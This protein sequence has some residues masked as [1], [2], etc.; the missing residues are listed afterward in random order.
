MPVIIVL[1]AFLLTTCAASAS[2]TLQPR[3]NIQKAIDAAPEG[4]VFILEP[5]VYRLQSFIPKDE[6]QFI[7]RTGAILNGAV[8]L[9][10]WRKE[11]GFW[12]RRG[13]PEPL[14]PHGRCLSK[15]KTCKHREDLFLNNSLYLRVA[16]L[17]DLG[18]GK[19]L[20]RSGV[21]YLKDDPSGRQV[22]LS[23][24]PLA[25]G[26]EAKGIVLKNLVVEKYASAA[27][28]GAIDARDGQDWQVINVIARWNHGIG[29]FI[30]EGMHV[31]GGS[32]N[33]NGQMGMG[34]EGSGAIIENVEIAFN[35]YAA[36]SWN[37]EAGGTK[38][39]RSKK[40]TVRNACV[41][42][43]IGPGLWTDIDN[44]DVLYEGNIVFE[45]KGDGIK[46]EISYKAVIRNNIAAR[47]GSGKDN[48]LWG[49]Q[50]LIQN[51]PNVQVYGN[52]VEVAAEFGNG[53]SIICKSFVECVFG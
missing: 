22:E 30:G 1:S 39:V 21:A 20:Y 28:R 17:D 31:T 49:S 53:I 33:H 32:F 5:G 26:G 29:L 47:N 6:Q 8:L 25:V 37:W 50:I 23:V 27:Q 34:G 36:F 7:G 15:N 35:N 43:N 10:G 3:D 24:T 42:H 45:N 19:W 9:S 2:V 38:F 44:I 16:S 11:G 18:P 51:S 52:I 41:H 40:L 48:W 46:H 13:L 4:T 12:T 14:R